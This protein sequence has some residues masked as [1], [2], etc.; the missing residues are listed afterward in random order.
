[1]PD[2][3]VP[4]AQSLG[5]PTR[6]GGGSGALMDS[7]KYRAISNSPSV[8]HWIVYSPLVI[9][10]MLVSHQVIDDACQAGRDLLNVVEV[11]LGD[12]LAGVAP[13]VLCHKLFHLR[14]RTP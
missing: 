13:L 6:H 7:S 2:H 9:R 10:Y 3:G 5:P 12:T 1:M 11:G 8:S 4:K 14:E